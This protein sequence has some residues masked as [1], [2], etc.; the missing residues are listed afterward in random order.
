MSSLINSVAAAAVVLF[1]P[2]VAAAQT[3]TDFSEAQGRALMA[4][5]NG[6]VDGGSYDDDGLPG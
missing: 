5:E 4:D 2:G 3:W 6:V 1:A